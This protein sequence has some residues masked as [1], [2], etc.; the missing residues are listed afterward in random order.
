MLSYDAMMERF[1]EFVDGYRAFSFFWMPSDESARL[2]CLEGAGADACA[3]RLFQE[4]DPNAGGELPAGERVDRAYRIYPMH[5][6]PNFHEMEYFLPLAHAH[7]IL[8]EMRKLMRRWLPLSV[9]P[10]EVR[11]VAGDEAWMSPNYQ[12]ENLVVS[13]SGQPGV[14]YWPYLRACDTLFAEFGGRPHW[15]KLHFMTADRLARHFPRYGDF[16]AM[17]ERFDPKG[18]FLNAHTRALFG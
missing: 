3:I 8:R 17:R 5:Y 2:Y 14:D 16:V 15:G 10:L 13:V 18:T 1:D 9:F 4:A 12:R 7:E 6:D 11:M